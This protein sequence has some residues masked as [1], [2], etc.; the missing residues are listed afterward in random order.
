MG[1]GHDITTRGNPEEQVH[2]LYAELQ[3]RSRPEGLNKVV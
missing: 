2:K 3:G 1:G